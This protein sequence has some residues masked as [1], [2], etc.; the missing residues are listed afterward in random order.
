MQFT[1]KNFFETRL[2]R[3]GFGSVFKETLPDSTV[4]AVKKLESIGQTQGENQF[5]IEADVFI[6]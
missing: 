6:D 5:R 4:V 2:G 3:G 1:T